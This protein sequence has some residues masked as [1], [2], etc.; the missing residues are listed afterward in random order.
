MKTTLPLACAVMAGFCAFTAKVETLDSPLLR[1][2]C[3]APRLFRHDGRFYLTQTGSTK[4]RVF[5]SD[6]LAGL[7]AADSKPRRFIQ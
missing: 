4:V 5:T 2:C 6:T 1:K 7:A 3:A